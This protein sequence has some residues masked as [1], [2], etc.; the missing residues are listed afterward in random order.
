MFRRILELKFCKE[1]QDNWDDIPKD[2]ASV[3]IDAMDSLFLFTKKAMII[4]TLH[5]VYFESVKSTKSRDF[6][7]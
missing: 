2:A 7:Q 4:N 1:T 6:D 5:N 3:C